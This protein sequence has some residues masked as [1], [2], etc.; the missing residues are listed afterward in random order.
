[1]FE[2]NILHLRDSVEQFIKEKNYSVK[3]NKEAKSS[4]I[5]SPL[6]RGNH[7]EFM[8]LHHLQYCQKSL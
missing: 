3:K 6:S 7:S 1:M 8:S 2:G 5:Y 4:V